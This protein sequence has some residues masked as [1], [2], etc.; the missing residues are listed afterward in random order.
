MAWDNVHSE[1]AARRV[2][3][4]LAEVR[5]GHWACIEWQGYK[6]EH[7]YGV[8]VVA[9]RKYYVHRVV[10][11][12]KLRRRLGAHELVMHRCDNPACANPAHLS[13]GTVRDNMAD[14]VSKR[15]MNAGRRGKRGRLLT[16]YEVAQIKLRLTF[17]HSVWR[18][19]DDF[20]CGRTTV[21][22]IRDNRTWKG[23]PWPEAKAASPVGG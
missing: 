1:R 3:A 12:L 10:M 20:G 14:A 7:G 23:V 19:A 9:G 4:R 21:K 8:C 13:V 6:N 16:P 17:R 5:R 22:D 15:R 11:E 18:I 2:F